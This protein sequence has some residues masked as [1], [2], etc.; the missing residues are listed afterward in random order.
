MVIFGVEKVPNLDRQRKIKYNYP[1]YAGNSGKARLLVMIKSLKKRKMNILLPLGALILAATLAACGN[2]P[3]GADGP[4]DF[5]EYGNDTQ[6]N[7][8]DQTNEGQQNNAD[9]TGNDPEKEAPKLEYMESMM[10]ED[11]YGDKAKYEVYAPKGSSYENGMVFYYE[12]GLTYA[13]S[14][15]NYGA[16][17]PMKECLADS[18]S[19]ETDLWKEQTSEYMDVKIGEVMES[20][21]NLYQI[22]SAKRKDVFDIPY[23]IKCIYYMDVKKDGLVVL[24]DVELSE[25]GMDE[26]TDLIIDELAQ[27]YG[28]NAE[29]IKPD[30]G[31]AVANEERI[32]AAKAKDSLPKTV[33]WFNATYAPLTQSNKSFGTN[34]K[35]VGGMKAS[36]YNAAFCRQGLIRDWN[37]EDAASALQTVEDLKEKGHRE[38]CRQCLEALAEMGILEAD[39]ET[40]FEALLASDIEENLSR[41]VIVYYMHK[42][43]MDA[44]DIAAWD[45]CRVNQLY[46]DFY[47][48]GYMTYEEA[49]DASLEN[50]LILQKMYSSWEDMVNSYMLGYQ[51]W[52]GDLALTEDSPTQQRY[53]CYLELLE[54]E[55]GPYTLDWNMDLIKSW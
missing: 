10:I 8:E 12:H 34:W 33:L 23:D 45:L 47:I 48:C 31:W 44:D 49:M 20:G 9:K 40:F 39:E 42:S 24:W 16:G 17:A 35:L 1:R 53:K 3:A 38:K 2:E 41:Y 6:K 50:S 55:N 21:N 29:A 22:A 52:R 26:K 25:P 54:M 27:C 28:F 4:T 37:I 43:G 32:Q 19:F 15:I 30:G 46:A 7:A 11:H 14:V 51:F 36:D 13:A 5:P 18:M